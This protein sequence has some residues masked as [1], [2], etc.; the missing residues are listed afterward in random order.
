MLDNGYDLV[1]PYPKGSIYYTTKL[2]QD[3]IKKFLND[4][5]NSYMDYIIQKYMISIDKQTIYYFLDTDLKNVVCA[6]GMQFFNTK[7]YIQG[8]GENEE[9]LD[10]GPEDYERIYR[11]YLLG[12]KIGWIDSGNIMH[13]DHK[14]TESSESNNILSQKNCKLWAKIFSNIDTKE[15][16][17]QYMNSLPYVIE[18][19]SK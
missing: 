4:P 3:H 9:F 8:Y 17:I 5:D 2:N 10:W 18:R 19:N 13:M 6:G 11:F 1:Y 15:K 7:S 14:K 16:M 12:Y